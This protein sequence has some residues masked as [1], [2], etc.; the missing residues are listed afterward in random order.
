MVNETLNMN[1][2]VRGHIEIK[3][4]IPDYLNLLIYNSTFRNQYGT[5]A[6]A[7]FVDSAAYTVV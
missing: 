2:G 6:C 1:F 4:E 5:L 3:S 7:L